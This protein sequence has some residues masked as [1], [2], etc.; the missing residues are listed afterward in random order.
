VVDGVGA[1][2]MTMS[3][4]WR[5]LST[6]SEV[7]VISAVADVEAEE[8]PG[9]SCTGEEE[10]DR[11]ER[12]EDR[13]EDAAK[14]EPARRNGMVPCV[15]KAPAGTFESLVETYHSAIILP[16]DLEAS[17]EAAWRKWLSAVVNAPSL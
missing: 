3:A 16:N 17:F 7:G 5:K 15:A 8:A 13:N 1:L 11:V 12:N 4:S 9:R 6:W 2:E 10:A 14:S